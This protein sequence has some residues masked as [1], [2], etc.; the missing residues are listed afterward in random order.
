MGCLKRLELTP[1]GI[2][3][4]F[5]ESRGPPTWL[6]HFGPICVV[7]VVRFCFH[8][9]CGKNSKRFKHPKI[10]KEP[11]R[12][13]RERENRAKFWPK[14]VEYGWPKISSA[15][16]GV[17][18]VVSHLCV[19]TTFCFQTYC[20]AERGQLRP[21]SSW[22]NFDFNQC[23]DVESTAVQPRK[24]GAPKGGGPKMLRVFFPLPPQCTFRVLNWR[25]RNR[26]GFT[27]HPENLNVHI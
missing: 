15:K 16:I 18:L 22:A 1:R 27:R 26:Q 13:W 8:K 14:S 6:I 9:C 20:W 11:L 2:L 24:M 12:L 3:V 10:H 4:V 5:F 23:Y 7:C 19:A 17:A 21:I 25:P